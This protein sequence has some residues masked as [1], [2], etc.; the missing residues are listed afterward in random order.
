M[1]ASGVTGTTS[2]VTYTSANVTAGQTPV[3][4]GGAGAD[5]LTGA[6][7]AETISGGA[8]ND[9][10][11]GNTGIDTLN[12]G[13]GNDTFNFTNAELL[14]TDIVS[15]GEGTDVI[16]VEDA[17]S[18]VDAD[19]ANVTSVETLTLVTNAIHTV[20]LGANSLAAGINTVTGLT[21]GV[22]TITVGAGHAGNIALNNGTANDVITVSAVPA[23]NT[24]TIA[25][26]AGND[27]FNLG[28]ATEVITGGAGNETY[29]FAAVASLS[30]A[31]VLNGV[32]GTDAITFGAAGTITDSMFTGVSNM[33][34]VTTTGASTLTLAGQA[35]E[36]GVLTVTLGNAGAGT[37]NTVDTSGM[38]TGL[39]KIQGGTGKDVITGTPQADAFDLG[40]TGDAW[41]N[42]AGII[43]VVKFA[44]TGA[45]NGI[46]TFGADFNKAFLQFDFSAF[47]SSLTFNSTAVQVGSAS[48]INITNTITMLADD[49]NGAVADVDTTT[50][51]FDDIKDIGDELHINAGGKAV[52]I[53]GADDAA[54]AGGSIY[55][56]DDSVD[57]VVGTL[58]AADVVKVATLTMDIDDLTAGNFI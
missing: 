40:T 38:T 21:G 41:V 43:D 53:A 14:G 10:I 30:S 35:V 15:G 16:N 9:T 6:A 27:T 49:T 37:Q 20:V 1:D 51:I 54:T 26:G 22:N 32:S 23:G 34:S 13:A 36:G 12:G 50:E 55:Y 18:I 44:A 8:G 46:D 42:G 11:E 52:I 17:S 31:D 28:A 29:A 45:T 4:T 58:S 19:F 57:G 5:V 48:D 7:L 47:S 33:D 39:T 2:I 24:V 25:G 3:M 56:V